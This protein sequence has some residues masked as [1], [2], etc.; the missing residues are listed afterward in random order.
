MAYFPGDWIPSDDDSE[1]PDSDESNT[2]SNEDS[3][4]TT[5]DDEAESNESDQVEESTDSFSNDSSLIFRIN[6]LYN[7]LES[8]ISFFLIILIHKLIK[9]NI[10]CLRKY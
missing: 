7:L 5:M 6:L 1:E 10:I 2:D 9:L 4:A 3:D 8:L